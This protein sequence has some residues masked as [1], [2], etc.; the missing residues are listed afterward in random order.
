MDIIPL[1]RAFL[2]LK[3]ATALPWLLVGATASVVLALRLHGDVRRIDMTHRIRD[4]MFL[5]V[6]LCAAAAAA[7]FI[8]TCFVDLFHIRGLWA[9]SD[10]AGRGDPPPRWPQRA[11]RSAWNPG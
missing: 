11:A 8:Q 3:V 1:D 6:A 7:Q 2:P 4:A 9:A 5:A 10:R